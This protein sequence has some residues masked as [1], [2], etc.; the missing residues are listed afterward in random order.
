MSFLFSGGTRVEVANSDTCLGG[1][2]VIQL[3]ALYTLNSVYEFDGTFRRLGDFEFFSRTL[4][5]DSGNRF[6]G[7]PLGDIPVPLP[8]DFVVGIDVQKWDIEKVKPSYL[9]GEVRRGLVVLLSY[10][11]AVKMPLGT[12]A[13]I[14]VTIPS[15]LLDGAKRQLRLGEG[16]LISVATVLL[17]VVSSQT[18]LNKHLRCYVLPAFP[19]LFVLCSRLMTLGSSPQG[20]RPGGQRLAQF[21]AV[22]VFLSGMSSMRAFP[23]S[24]SYFNEAAGGIRTGGFHLL[25]SNVAWGQDLIYL[26]EWL[27]EHPEAGNP[28]MAIHASFDPRILGFEFAVPPMLR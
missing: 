4:G 1:I 14:A 3:L 23:H 25:S 18:H 26:K 12:L 16:V 20:G 22:A 2:F 24:M 19:F 9:R 21:A 6:R 5:G 28:A 11:M 15:L 13:L 8:D 10:A 7:G 17:V 27:E